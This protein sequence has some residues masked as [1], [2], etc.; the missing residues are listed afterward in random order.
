MPQ[1]AASSLKAALDADW[2]DRAAR[3][4]ALAG[5]LG[6]LER[7]EAFL[8]GEAG[9]ER[10]K[11]G[12]GRLPGPGP[13]RGLFRTGARAAP[14]GGQRPADQRRRRPDAARAQVPLGPVRWLQAARADRPGYRPG[15]RRRHHPGQRAGGQRHRRYHHRPGRRQASLAE[16][17]IDRAYRSALVGLRAGPGDLLQGLAGPN[18][19]GRFAKDEFSLDFAAGQ[20]TC[21]AGVAM[22]FQPGKTAHF[23][24]ATCAACPLRQRCTTSAW[25]QRRH[26]P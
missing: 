2:D 6:L 4:Q 25:A 18:S 3:D 17:H 26:P 7:V 1:P 14:R 20:L 22:P 12:R 19:S 13:G 24:K 23:P 9:Q 15:D 11:G 21:P 5:V 10:G 8:A 16:L